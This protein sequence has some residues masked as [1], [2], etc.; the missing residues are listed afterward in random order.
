MGNEAVSCNTVRE[1]QAAVPHHLQFRQKKQCPNR[2]SCPIQISKCSLKAVNIKVVG[3]NQRGV[4]DGS[5]K[6][7]LVSYERRFHCLELKQRRKQ[8]QGRNKL[9]FKKM[10]G[11]KTG[12]VETL[13]FHLVCT[14][15][16]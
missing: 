10:D 1:K 16:R 12:I 13:P 14:R 2:A 3:R 8:Q 9:I 7:I 5:G 6:S 15:K 11:F 4:M